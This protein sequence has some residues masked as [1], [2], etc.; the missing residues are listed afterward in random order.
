MCWVGIMNAF[1]LAFCQKEIEAIR[2]ENQE[3]NQQGGKDI[4]HGNR[5]NFF[6]GFFYLINFRSMYRNFSRRNVSKDYIENNLLI[7][8]FLNNKKKLKK[9]LY[10][11][12]G[13]DW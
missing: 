4:F 3:Q 2:L 8:E 6:S 13:V 11:S 1:F 5:F 7:F 10:S 12:I 9:N